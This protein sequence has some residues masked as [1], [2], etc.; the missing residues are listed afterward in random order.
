M[1]LPRHCP[2]LNWIEQVITVKPDKMAVPWIF[3]QMWRRQQKERI[4]IMGLQDD[5]MSGNI[6][7]IARLITRLLLQGDM[8]QYTLPAAEAD[9]TEADRLFSKI[10]GLADEGDINGAENELLMNMEGITV[11]DRKVAVKALERAQQTG[12]P[13]AA[14]E[15][16]D[17]RIITGKTSNLLGASAALLVNVLK[18]LAGIDH[19]VHIISPEAIEP[20]QKLKVDYLNSK[21]PRLHTDE[22]LIALSASAAVNPIAELALSQLPKLKGCQAHTS[23]M[24]S[25]V[26]IK[27]FKK[28]GV[29]LTSEAVNERQ[30]LS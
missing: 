19:N 25:S 6:Q 18:E 21:N 8:P 9:Y 3:V 5:R 27:T 24:L 13:A 26:D 16:E 11:S 12:G 29:Q 20:I 2:A 28:L 15:L 17:G 23:V 1:R 30:I 4:R 7:D 14:L 10:I 22:I